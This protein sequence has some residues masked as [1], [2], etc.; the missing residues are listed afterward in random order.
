M[1]H[2][3]DLVKLIKHKSRNTSVAVGGYPDL[4]PESLSLQSDMQYLNEKVEA[5]ADFIITQTCFSSTKIVQ[6]IA[7]CRD[8][9]I[10]VPIVPGVFIPSSYNALMSMCRLCN[11]RV[12]EEE[13][14]IYKLLKEDLEAFQDYAVGN[15]IKLLNDLFHNDEDVVV[16]VHFFTLNNFELVKRVTSNFDFK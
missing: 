9:G 4:H 1:Q 10:K 8:V 13:F 12:P 6:F 11:I 16:G 14:R 7:K 5:G 15:A 2:A 3:V